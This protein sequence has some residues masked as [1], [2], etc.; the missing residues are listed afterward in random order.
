MEDKQSID[1]A[2]KRLLYTTIAEIGFAGLFAFATG[3]SLVYGGKMLL[4]MWLSYFTIPLAAFTDTFSGLSLSAW[5]VVV[6]AW[7]V[8]FTIWKYY[9]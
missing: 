5:Y 7:I 9:E 2:L 8:S 1:S 4:A 3:N 6:L